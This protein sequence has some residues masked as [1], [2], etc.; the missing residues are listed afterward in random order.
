MG[1]HPEDLK[2]LKN[3]KE[4]KKMQ[5]LEIYPLTFQSMTLKEQKKP[6]RNES[7]FL[8]QDFSVKLCAKPQWYTKINKTVSFRVQRN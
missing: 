4:R 8:L 1:T 6:M 7:V 5:L 2:K 3:K